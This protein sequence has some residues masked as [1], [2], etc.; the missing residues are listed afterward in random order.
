MGPNAMI[1]VFWMLSF[2]PTFS[3]SSFTFIK[4]LFISSLSALRVV[5]SA[6]LRLLIFLL[7]ILIPACA[8]SNP[9]YGL[10]K[11]GDNI[12][13]WQYTGIKPRSPAL[14]VDSLPCEPPRKNGE[15]L[16]KSQVALV[17]KNP[18][19]NAGD[20]RDMGQVGSLGWED[21]LEKEMATHSSILAWEIP[22]TEKPGGLQSMGSERVGYD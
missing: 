1:L 17:V 22:W 10:N 4:R 8:S 16:S 6:Y 2:K 20:S 3:L 14:Q 18:A 5:S 13:P 7:A 21:P 11:H 19:T 15:T 12:Q 9:Q